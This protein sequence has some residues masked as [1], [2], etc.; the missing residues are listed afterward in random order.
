LAVKPALL[1]S[2]VSID[3]TI[4]AGSIAVMHSS[5]PKRWQQPSAGDYAY[6]KME[7]G[8]GYFGLTSFNRKLRMWGSDPLQLRL[9][10][11][12]T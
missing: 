9:G 3:Q 4:T 12:P 11:G 5:N 1:A 8:V 6:H 2:T 10:F 7:E